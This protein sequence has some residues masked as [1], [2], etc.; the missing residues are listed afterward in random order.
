MLTGAV[1]FVVRAEL[2]NYS[3]GMTQPRA[4]ALHCGDTEDRRMTD[5]VTTAQMRMQ[6]RGT[7]PGLPYGA[8]MGSDSFTQ[9]RLHKLQSQID[10]QM[11]MQSVNQ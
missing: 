8:R 5:V 4:H 6:T 3:R 7:E 11:H 2:S 1:F 10:L 9:F